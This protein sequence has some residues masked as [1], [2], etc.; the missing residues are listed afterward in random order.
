M[1]LL[2][3]IQDAAID[4]SVE[5]TVL[6]RKCKVLA[7][8]LGNAE[9]KQWVENELNG[10]NS[11]EELPDY[12]II[13]VNSKGHFS[14]PFGSGLNYADIPL[15]CIPENFRKNLQYCHFMEPVAA[16]EV[17]V[18]DSEEGIAQE[19]WNPDLVVHVG[20]KIYKQMNCIQAWKV[21]P[22]SAIAATLDAVRNRILSFV[23]EIEAEAPDAGEA[24]INSNPVSQDRLHQIF[25]TYITGNVQNVATGSTHVE[26]NAQYNAGANDELFE[27]LID[28]ISDSSVETDLISEIVTALEGMRANQG[29]SGYKQHYLSFMSILADHMQVL[30]PIVAPFLPA[31]S[32]ILS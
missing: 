16:M 19:P 26:Q 10:Y 31:L 13:R 28:A 11:I 21:I 3:E 4:S 2:R 17:L 9:F 22:I 24:P 23:L 30:G 27:K 20:K 18:A 6:L 1:S 14:G 15:F 32:G 29:T 12:R 8:K 25:N 5:L 7:A